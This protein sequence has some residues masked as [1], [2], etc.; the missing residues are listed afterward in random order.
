MAFHATSNRCRL[1]APGLASCIPPLPTSPASA[2]PHTLSSASSAF[3]LCSS[4]PAPLL[5]YLPACITSPPAILRPPCTPHLL[6]ARGQLDAGDAGIGVVGHNDG[7]VARAARQ[8]AAV[9][10]G[11]GAAQ[12]SGRAQRTQRATTRNIAPWSCCPRAAEAAGRPLAPQGE[13]GRPLLLLPTAVA[14]V[15][16]L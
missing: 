6:G 7:V 4:P 12:R 15:L 14:T 16:L 10:C 13:A 8:G 11:T 2:R 5:Q 3:P 9:A 1:A